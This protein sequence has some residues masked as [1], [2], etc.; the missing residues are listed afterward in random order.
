MNTGTFWLH[1]KLCFPPLKVYYYRNVSFLYSSDLPVVLIKTNGIDGCCQIYFTFYIIEA[2]GDCLY[3]ANVMLDM[4]RC[5][6]YITRR[7]P[8]LGKNKDNLRVINSTE[9]KWLLQDQ[10]KSVASLLIDW[11]VSSS[12]KV[13]NVVII[14]RGLQ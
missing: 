6:S 1:I 14:R 13:H 2:Q 11:Y 9:N 10:S 12:L 7:F 3:M 5:R 4:R 8:L